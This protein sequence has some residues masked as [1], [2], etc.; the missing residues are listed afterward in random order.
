MIVFTRECRILITGA[1]SGIGRAIALTCNALGA[2]VIANG[3]D[4][5]KLEAVKGESKHPDAFHVE[6]LDLL[7]DLDALPFWVKELQERYGKL[8]GLVC[9]AGQAGI[10]PLREYSYAQARH[11]FDINFHAPLLLAKGFAD[12]RNNVGSGSGIIFISSAA[13][14]AKEAGL[15]AYGGAKAALITAMESLSKEYASQGIRVNALAP[16]V[17]QTPMGQAFLDLLSEEGMQKE[18]AAY[19]L[20]IGE[21]EDVAN[22]AVFLLSDAGKWITGQTIVMDGGRY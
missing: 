14:I 10:M 7:T 18:Q 9:C 12:R 4:R 2:A 1:S 11:L 17:V 3:R 6:P 5:D 15:A 21:P 19:P 22:M 8:R 16:A 13:A 20:G